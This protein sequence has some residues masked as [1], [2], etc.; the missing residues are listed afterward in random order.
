MNPE[1]ERRSRMTL[2][3]RADQAYRQLEADRAH[4]CNVERMQQEAWQ[5]DNLNTALRQ[6]GI[7]D[8]V[9][10]CPSRI[11]GIWFDLD[12]DL[13]LVVV[14]GLPC[15]HY[16]D[17]PAT[18]LAAIGRSLATESECPVCS[19]QEKETMNKPSEGHS[20]TAA[21]RRR[22]NISSTSKG[23]LSF[24]TTVDGVGTIPELLAELDAQVE[25]L[26][27]RTLPVIT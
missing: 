13:D 5:I 3:D 19:E 2:T 4:Q 23:V 24:E 11:D 9:T 18:S 26:Q 25:A 1:S 8:R 12:I 22:M 17:M 10:E 21:L 20:V 27:L 16:D 7:E 15:G 14:K 6:V